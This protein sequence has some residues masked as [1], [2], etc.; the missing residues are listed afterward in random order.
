MHTHSWIIKPYHV[1]L[2][3]IY[4]SSLRSQNYARVVLISLAFWYICAM[5]LCPRHKS[6]N[7][8]TDNDSLD[9]LDGSAYNNA[10]TCCCLP[11]PRLNVIELFSN[12]HLSLA[13][14]FKK[15]Q[16]QLELRKR[17]KL[18]FDAFTHTFISISLHNKGSEVVAVANKTIPAQLPHR[19]SG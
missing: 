2:L 10:A 14:T 6:T 15:L 17:N 8:D 16:L 5:L 4:M 19:Y 13:K 3:P 7:N 12:W 18:N 9:I 1:G 11:P